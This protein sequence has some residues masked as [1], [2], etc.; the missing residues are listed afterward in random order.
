MHYAFFSADLPTD[1]CVNT[2]ESWTRDAL[3]IQFLMVV[4]CARMVQ[5]IFQYELIVTLN[6]P[7]AS[8]REFFIALRNYR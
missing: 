7:A 8:G 5:D 1:H 6:L 4:V 2:V 3:V